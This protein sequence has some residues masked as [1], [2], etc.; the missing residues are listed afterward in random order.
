M[1][2]FY[3]GPSKVYPQVGDYLQDAFKEGILSVNHRSAACMALVKSTIELLHQKLN[4]P[5]DYHIYFVSSATESWEIIAQSL[6]ST[7]S[8]HFFNGA[9]G[10]KWHEYTQKLGVQAYSLPFGL[11]ES[12]SMPRGIIP[13]TV[14][15]FTH[16]ET[17][18][19]TTLQNTVLDQYQVLRQHQEVLL[20]IDATSSMG[21]V[22]LNWSLTDVWFASVQ[23]CFGLPAGLGIMV[24]SPQAINRAYEIGERVHYNSLIAI[25]ENF[26]K[27]QTHYTP[28]VLGIYLLKRVMEQ[29]ANISEIA[30]MLKTRATGWYE[31]IENQT[32]WKI[33]VENKS[34]R[35]DTVITIK[36]TPEAINSIKSKCL[37]QGITLGNGYGDWKDS[38]FRIAN[39]PA[40]E[41]WE[42]EKLKEV[43]REE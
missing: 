42:I 2:T 17:S 33:L 39:F 3:P 14:C 32:S 25:H 6:V 1:I 21:G 34:L 37:Q 13:K 22:E 7:S 5:T 15:C 4:I 16:N 28:N 40:I 38:T 31:F 18:N 27:Y 26:Q 8:Y 41:A 23:K 20:A 29:V 24:C 19:G 9:F 11:N 10:K 36:G 43:L 35:S 12:P 30:A